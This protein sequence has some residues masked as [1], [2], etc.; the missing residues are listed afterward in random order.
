MY[1]PGKE[2]RETRTALN[3]VFGV[4]QI[5][6]FFDAVSEC[7]E[8][9]SNHF[10]KE[11]KDLQEI[12]LNDVFS[13]YEC[14]VASRACFGVVSNSL[15][16]KHNDYFRAYRQLKSFGAFERLKLALI[17]LCPLLAKVSTS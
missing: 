7:A 2:W 13:R 5:E 16:D 4:R 15:E 14:D 12:Q 1:V 6:S 8:V 9:F 3:Y 11:D 17:Q 10:V